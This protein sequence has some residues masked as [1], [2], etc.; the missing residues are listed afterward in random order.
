MV[1]LDVDRPLTAPAPASPLRLAALTLGGVMAD[2]ADVSGMT[3]RGHWTP[4][5]ACIRGWWMCCGDATE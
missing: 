4:V 2:A 3:G 5:T 1:G